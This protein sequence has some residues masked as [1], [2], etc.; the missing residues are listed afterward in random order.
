MD[1]T[2]Y[3]VVI[4]DDYGMGPETSRGIL[5]LAAAGVIG[6]A[7]LIVNTPYAADAVAGWRKSG[8][9]CDL[10]WHPNLTMDPPC[11]R[12]SQVP[13][14]VGPD[15]CLWPLGSFVLRV[16][17]GR[18]RAAEVEIEL[19]AQYDRFLTMVGHVPRVVNSHQ[20]VAIFPPIGD[21]LLRVLA[22]QRPLP[23]LR[24]VREPWSMLARI[25]GAKIKRTL[26]TVLGGHHARAQH[27]LNFPGADWLAGITDPPWVTDPEFFAR[28]LTQVPGRVVELACHPGQHDATLIGRDCGASDGLLK[29][30]VDELHLLRQ[31]RF[32]EACR[33]GGF[34]RVA[35]SA[36]VDGDVRGL[37]HAA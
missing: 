37:P 7:V 33:Q 24:R 27:R 11:A 12:A 19:R 31:P 28:W 18:I 36:L 34:V 13:S 30:R 5:E 10:G 21:I 20:H 9:T 14:L 2:R 25:P 23:Y 17:T 32:L 4:A 6:G 15:G 22:A 16:L 8:V 29:R 1:A 35:P 3:L 26:L